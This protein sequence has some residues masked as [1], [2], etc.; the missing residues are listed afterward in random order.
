MAETALAADSTVIR[1]LVTWGT[2]AEGPAAKR[3]AKKTC[4]A[5]GCCCECICC[6]L[7]YP[8]LIVWCATEWFCATCVP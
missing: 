5:K 2:F 8:R 7:K 3:F 1:D 4:V 6:E